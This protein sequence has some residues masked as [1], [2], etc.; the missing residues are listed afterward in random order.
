M[1]YPLNPLP[2]RL[3]ELLE[4]QQEPFLLE[5]GCS[6]RC[7]KSKGAF[8]CWNLSHH[9]FRRRRVRGGILRCLAAKLVHLKA[10]KKAL[11]CERSKLA[12]CFREVRNEANAS[13]FHRLSF[14]SAAGRGE[15][16]GEIGWKETEHS[17]VS[18]L[19]LHC[20]ESSSDHNHCK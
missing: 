11:N 9:G 15:S 2:R 16:S 12:T 8:R 18:V 10:L 17:P 1:A 13:G 6:K 4:E 14:S 19:E 3:F 5:L 7:L 20:D